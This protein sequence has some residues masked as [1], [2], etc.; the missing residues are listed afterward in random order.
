MPGIHNKRN[1]VRFVDTI[2]FTFSEWQE[3][4]AYDMFPVIKKIADINR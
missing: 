4:A 3:V 1:A 2:Y